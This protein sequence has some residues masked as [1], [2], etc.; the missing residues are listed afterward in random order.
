MSLCLIYI[1]RTLLGTE[2]IWKF[3][4]YYFALITMNILP[5]VEHN[6]DSSSFIPK[7]VPISLATTYQ[8]YIGR[9]L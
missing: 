2:Y 1:G 5:S 6:W 8:F 9:Y 7:L 3:I 4:Y